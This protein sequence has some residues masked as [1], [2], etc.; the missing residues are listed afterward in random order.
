MPSVSRKSKDYLLVGGIIAFILQRNGIHLPFFIDTALGMMW[1]YSLGYCLRN[2][3]FLNR[4]YKVYRLLLIIVCYSIVIL[5]IKPHV[6][7]NI[8]GL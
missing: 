6:N 8:L 4:D 7:I 1:F 5:L 2:I 3:G